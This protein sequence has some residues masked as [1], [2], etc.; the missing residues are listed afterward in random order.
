[1]LLE[2]E[3]GRLVAENRVLRADVEYW[4]RIG[5]KMLLIGGFPELEKLEGAILESAGPSGDGGEQGE[6][7]QGEAD[8]AVGL[9]GGDRQH[10]HGDAQ[11]DG[12][13]HRLPP[14]DT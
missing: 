13:Q 9:T 8:P 1:V 2:G 12:G 14:R 3:N 11:Q 6:H 5:R 7:A 10:D 4:G